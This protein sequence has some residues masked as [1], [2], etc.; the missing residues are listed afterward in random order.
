MSS[1]L[2]PHAVV[3][4]DGIEGPCDWPVTGW[5]W[6]QDVEHEDMLSPACDAHANEGGRRIHAAEQENT[7]LRELLAQAKPFV[8]HNGWQL[9][10]GALGITSD[11]TYWQA[12]LDPTS[13]AT[14][15][16]HNHFNRDIKAPGQCPACDRYHGQ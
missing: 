15:A 8:R 10:V 6:Y 9:Q 3:D 14:D 16:Q 4:A 5:R 13:G 12:T 11:S 1:E 7:R 2:C